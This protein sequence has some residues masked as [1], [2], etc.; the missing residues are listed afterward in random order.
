MT[1]HSRKKKVTIKTK[2]LMSPWITQGLIKSSRSFERR[3]DENEKQH[4]T[5]KKFKKIKKSSKK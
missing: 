2:N 4:K 5:Y 3:R 1:L